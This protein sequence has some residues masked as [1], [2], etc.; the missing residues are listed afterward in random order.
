MPE[1]IAEDASASGFGLSAFGLVALLVP[2]RRLL[3]QQTEDLIA[4]CDKGSGALSLRIMRRNLAEGQILRKPFRRQVF[5]RATQ[6]REER[7]AGGVGPADAAVEVRGDFGAA[8]GVLEHPYVLL[9]RSNKDGHL[10][11]PHPVAGLFEHAAR[12]FDAF[13]T[14]AGGENHTSSPVFLRSDGDSLENR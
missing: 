11:E 8:E 14:L 12:D 10:I 4:R 3:Q 2:L 1:T 7:A 13:P 5:H 6:H 9:R